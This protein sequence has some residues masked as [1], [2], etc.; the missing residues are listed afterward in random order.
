MILAAGQSRRWQANPY[1]GAFLFLSLASLLTLLPP[2]PP[3]PR[4]NAASLVCLRIDKQDAND[5]ETQ[6]ARGRRR[7]SVSN[8]DPRLARRCCC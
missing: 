7:E 1:G 3:Q 4:L 2:P 5:E 6:D 8:G